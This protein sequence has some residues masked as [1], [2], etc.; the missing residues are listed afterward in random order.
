MIYEH[1]KCSDHFPPCFLFMIAAAGGVAAPSV[2]AR[3]RLTSRPFPE[4]QALIGRRIGRLSGQ[5]G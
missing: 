2:P 3:R 4:A 5:V 1:R